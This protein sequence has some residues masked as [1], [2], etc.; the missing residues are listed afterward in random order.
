MVAVR[1]GPTSAQYPIRVP[2]YGFYRSLA[3]YVR[4]KVRALGLMSEGREREKGQGDDS[5]A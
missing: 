4:D 2:D 3:E 5:A 1:A